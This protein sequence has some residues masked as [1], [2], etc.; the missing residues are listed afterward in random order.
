M[1]TLF[2]GGG[3]Q[4]HREVDLRKGFSAANRQT[5]ARGCVE[6]PVLANFLHDFLDCHAASDKF[7]GPGIANLR[8]PAAGL[9][10]FAVIYVGQCGAVRS[11]CFQPVSVMG[12]CMDTLPAANALFRKERN[13]LGRAHPF[14]VVAPKAAQGTTFQEHGRA[15]AGPIVD[16]EPLDI[17]N[18][19]HLCASGH[20]RS[21]FRLSVGS[22]CGMNLRPVAAGRSPGKSLLAKDPVH[23]KLPHLGRKAGE[24]G[25]ESCH[26]H[27]KVRKLGGILVAS[28]ICSLLRMLI[29]TCVPPKSQCPRIK[30][31][32]FSTSSGVLESWGRDRSGAERCFRIRAARRPPPRPVP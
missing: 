14:G 19:T 28:R 2:P 3:E 20:V 18:A 26:A 29:L 17:K 11:R 13:N 27:D 25:A 32:T 22:L 9:A 8:A 16:R 10:A 6:G 15:D 30:A 31:S 23:N 7:Q 1:E 12:T 4:C 21:P 5:P 24:V